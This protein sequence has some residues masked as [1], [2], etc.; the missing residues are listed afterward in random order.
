MVCPYSGKWNE[1]KQNHP[2]TRRRAVLLPLHLPR[3]EPL[4]A[5]AQ[6]AAQLRGA[7]PEMAPN[8]VRGCWCSGR[9]SGSLAHASFSDV[10]EPLRNSVHI[11]SLATSGVLDYYCCVWAASPH[12]ISVISVS[13]VRLHGSV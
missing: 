7:L 2:S 11:K 10:T 5:H 9:C 1:S 13:P 3:A 6:Q 12:I 4:Q 8:E